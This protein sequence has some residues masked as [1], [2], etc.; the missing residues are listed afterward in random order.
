MES[1]KIGAKEIAITALL[2][3]ICIGS[4]FFKNLSIFITGPIIN[5]CIA[6]AVLLVN[7]PCGIILSVI[8]PITA[9]LIAA[10]PV[11]T[12]VPGI[13]GLIM[14]GNIVLAVAV[15]LLLKGIFTAEKKPLLKP[16]LYVFAVCSALA[17]GLFMGATISYWLLPTFLP[18]K[19]PLR[20]KIAV[21][22][23]MFSIN[24]FLT[25]LIG[26]AYVFILFPVL[27]KVLARDGQ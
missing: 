15:Q 6:L 4:Q 25:A 20:E 17:K 11:M 14:G 8:T 24:Q 18:A 5:A 19:G 7:L 21:F 27:K 2:L 3:A 13:I 26:M 16:L 22:Q 23:T 12:A 10:S 9:Y 1:R